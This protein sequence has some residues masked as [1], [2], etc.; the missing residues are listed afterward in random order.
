MLFNEGHG[1]ADGIGLGGEIQKWHVDLDRRH[2][3]LQRHAIGI[4]LVN[5]SE[6]QGIVLVHHQLH[7]TLHHFGDDRPLDFQVVADVVQRRITLADLV[8]PDGFLRGGQREGL[9]LHTITCAT[10]AKTSL[11]RSF[12]ATRSPMATAEKRF[13]KAFSE[14]CQCHLGHSAAARE[15]EAKKLLKTPTQNI[16][17]GGLA[18]RASRG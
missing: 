9:R 4:R 8:E 15:V 10:A 11:E 16:S 12:F 5:Q 13:I 7:G 17:K 14:F 1:R 3:R 2:E 18:S 6:A